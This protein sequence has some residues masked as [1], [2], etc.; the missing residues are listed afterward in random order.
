MFQESYLESTNCK[1]NIV[2]GST[3]R[4]LYDANVKNDKQLD[5]KEGDTIVIED[6]LPD[7]DFWMKGYLLKDPTKKG[8]VP[9]TFVKMDSKDQESLTKGSKCKACIDC[10]ADEDDELS[11]KK[12]DIIIITE[13]IT[14][15]NGWIEGFLENDPSKCGIFPVSYVSPL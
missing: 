13:V 8:L 4:A 10:K 5:F 1:S 7:D 6:V 2:N 12:G 14:D 9:R 15:D 3:V 11:F